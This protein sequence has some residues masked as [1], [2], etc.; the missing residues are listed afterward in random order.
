M[1]VTDAKLSLT[2][3]LVVSMRQWFETTGVHV[4]CSP[5]EVVMLCISWV[6]WQSGLF[7][8][9]A[10]VQCYAAHFHIVSRVAIAFPCLG[11]YRGKDGL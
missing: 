7:C 8:E 6:S 10:Y 9:S 11:H 2:D 3:P 5:S 1:L 4:Y